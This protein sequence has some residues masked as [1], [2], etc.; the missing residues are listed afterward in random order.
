MDAD[1]FATLARA[2]TEARSRRAALAAVLGGTLALLGLADTT[3]TKGKDKKDKHKDK[4]KAGCNVDLDCPGREIC[5][6]GRCGPPDCAFNDDCPTNHVCSLG[7]CVLGC[8]SSSDCEPGS[9]CRPSG[10]CG[11]GECDRDADC[12]S[13]RR[14]CNN[15][16]QCYNA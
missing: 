10:Q 3:A 2:L 14:Y 12:P 1:R 6:G 5:N 16:H 7:R 11:I 13:D 4:K 15:Q 9:S 8:S